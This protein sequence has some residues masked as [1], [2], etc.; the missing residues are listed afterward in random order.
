VDFLLPLE[1]EQEENQEGMEFGQGRLEVCFWEQRETTE[2][3]EK[4]PQGSR[5]QRFP[6]SVKETTLIG[7]GVVKLGEG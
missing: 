7:G 4:R 6:L 1:C 3:L 2:D 5:E